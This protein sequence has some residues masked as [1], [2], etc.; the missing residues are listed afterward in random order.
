MSRSGVVPSMGLSLAQTSLCF[1]EGLFLYAITGGSGKI[2][3]SVLL[4]WINFQ[5]FLIICD[6]AQR[7]NK[8]L[9]IITELCDED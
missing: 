2:Q 8:S 7:L 9:G 4:F 6:D 3:L 5:C 1:R